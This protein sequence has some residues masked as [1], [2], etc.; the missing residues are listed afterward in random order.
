LLDLIN[1]TSGGEHNARIAF[2]TLP[3]SPSVECIAAIATERIES[4]QEVLLKYGD[5][6]TANYLYK[7][8]FV[9]GGTNTVD[10][11]ISKYDATA[12]DVAHIWASLTN[13]QREAL[14]PAGFT[15]QAIDSAIL[16]PDEYPFVLPIYNGKPAAG[17]GMMAI[18]QPLR[19]IAFVACCDE[20]AQR[21][22]ECGGPLRTNRQSLVSAQNIDFVGKG[23]D[24][25]L[26]QTSVCVPGCRLKMARSSWPL[27]SPLPCMSNQT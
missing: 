17:A 8:G 14:V 3:G 2:T 26:I 18:P 15:Q 10:P 7:F 25:V 27:R 5:F 9:L 4:G 19:E 12:L 11:A 16:N 13:L 22:L 21:W 24:V 20:E 1:G 23:H 6:S